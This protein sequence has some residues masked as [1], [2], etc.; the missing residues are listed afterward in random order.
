MCWQLGR[1]TDESCR[2]LLDK[3]GD[4]QVL[5]YCR[6]E[7]ESYSKFIPE[8]RHW[9]GKEGTQRIERNNVNFRTQ[10]KRLQ[11]ETICFSKFLRAPSKNR[12]HFFPNY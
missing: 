3:L 2:K 5:R 9:I 8:E 4:C 1:R 12:L 6:D 10:L 11:R 7:L